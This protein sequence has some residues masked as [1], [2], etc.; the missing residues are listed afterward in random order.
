MNSNDAH[1]RRRRRRVPDPPRSLSGRKQDAAALRS[2]GSDPA[3]LFSPSQLAYRGAAR[4]PPCLRRYGCHQGSGA[5]VPSALR[6]LP[7]C[8]H[9]QHDHVVQ[10]RTGFLCPHTQLQTRPDVSVSLTSVQQVLDKKK[11]L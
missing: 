5:V 6:R 3:S 11:F 8:D 10:E 2:S 9:H 1:R 7:G 4:T